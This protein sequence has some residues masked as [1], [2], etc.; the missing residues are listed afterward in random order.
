MDYAVGKA[1]RAT[2]KVGS[3]IDGTRGIPVDIGIQLYKSLVRPH[4]E[5]AFPV[6]ANIKDNDIDKL[7]NAQL[8][9]LRRQW[10]I[11]EYTR[12]YIP[13]S[14]VFLTAYTHLSDHK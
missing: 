6:W 3:L 4:L 10:C 9:C 2:A 13:T 8:Q 5:Y 14:G 12:V 11:G 1:K 7:E